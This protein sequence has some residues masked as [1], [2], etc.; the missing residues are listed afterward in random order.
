MTCCIYPQIG[1]FHHS[2]AVFCRLNESALMLFMAPFSRNLPRDCV[3][4]YTTWCT[5]SHTLKMRLVHGMNKMVV[6]NIQTGRI[7]EGKRVSEYLEESPFRLA[8]PHSQGL[9][10]FA[11][12]SVSGEGGWG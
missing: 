2:L 4:G 1:P 11:N 12:G 10:M 7:S 5:L 8:R 6:G 3:M 9:A